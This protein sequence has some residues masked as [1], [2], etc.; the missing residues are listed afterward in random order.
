MKI[1]LSIILGIGI[2]LFIYSCTNKSEKD[3]S[4]TIMIDPKKLTP[5][6][7]QHEELS[8]DQLEKIKSIHKIFEKVYPITLEETI[9]N[10]KRDA[11]IDR[12]INLWLNM[13]E[14]FVDVMNEKKYSTIEEKKEVFKLILMRT[15]VPGNEVK[16][17]LKIKELSD[18]DTDYILSEF[19]NQM[20]N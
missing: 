7:I 8:K 6:P 12:E 4:E 13:K 3:K 17:Y 20:N 1:I 19:E 15:M 5:G 11:H 18:S 14:T 2:I 16:N 9:K 10:F